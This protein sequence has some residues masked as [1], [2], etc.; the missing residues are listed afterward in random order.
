[1]GPREQTVALAILVLSEP[2]RRL[3]EEDREDLYEL[4]KELA[5]AASDEDREGILATMIEILDGGDT[6]V[7]RLDL[8]D[9]ETRPH[10]WMKWVGWVSGRIREA[11]KEAGLTQAQLAARS[12]LPQSHIS[13][14]ENARH[15]PSRATIEKIAAA[16][17]RH[18]DHF[19]C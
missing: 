15:S 1:M 7:E 17:N 10:R 12:G 11:R 4:L 8:K 16:L 19:V 18:V 2:L 6:A 13:R 14:I 5:G 3:P 9:D